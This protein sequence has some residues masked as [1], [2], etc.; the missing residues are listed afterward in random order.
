MLANSSPVSLDFDVLF[1]G[2]LLMLGLLALMLTPMTMLSL[3]G[4]ESTGGTSR[5]MIGLSVV[6]SIGWGLG[7][8]DLGKSVETL[9][10]RKE[11]REAEKAHFCSDR[12]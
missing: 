6:G 10:V 8:K 7:G 4:V 1:L 3:S 9:P 11:R 12:P 5:G 2:T